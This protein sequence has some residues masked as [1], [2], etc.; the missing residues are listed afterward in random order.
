MC[1]TIESMTKW[2]VQIEVCSDSKKSRTLRRLGLDISLERFRSKC[3]TEVSFSILLWLT[4]GESGN[5]DVE[6][7]MVL[8]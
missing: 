3:P 1:D 8:N 2:W 6:P 5:E 4:L 7:E